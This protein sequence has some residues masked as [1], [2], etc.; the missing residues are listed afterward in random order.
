MFGGGLRTKRSPHA[1]PPNA[2][3]DCERAQTSSDVVQADGRVV[4]SGA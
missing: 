1:S 4:H 2:E 3:T